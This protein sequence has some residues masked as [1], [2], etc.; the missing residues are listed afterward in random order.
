[1]IISWNIDDEDGTGINPDDLLGSIHISHDKSFIQDSVTYLDAWFNSLIDGYRAIYA[2]KKIF[3]SDLI[4]EPDPLCF[5]CVDSKVIITYQGIS[6]DACPIDEF[7][8][9]LFESAIQLLKTIE[10]G[11]PEK[12]RT[13]VSKIEEFTKHKG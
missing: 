13:M 1:M 5:E 8:T 7:F 12:D 10:A 2:G 3:K 6:L 11:A 9:A 4:D